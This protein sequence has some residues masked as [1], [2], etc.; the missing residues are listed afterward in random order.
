[1][2]ASFCKS[3]HASTNNV[4]PDRTLCYTILLPGRKPGFRVAFQP[5]SSRESFKIGLQAGRKPAGGPISKLSRKESAEFQPG[6]PISGPEALLRN[7]GQCIVLKSK[8]GLQKFLG[9]S[10][11]HDCTTRSRTHRR[12]DAQTWFSA[13]RLR[14]GSAMTYLFHMACST[15]GLRRIA[16][17]SLLNLGM[18]YNSQ[19]S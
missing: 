5:D 8:R 4:V 18:V 12:I 13:R 15:R 10:A 1:M 17:A 3:P 6:S 19:Y 11:Y 16:N 9:R 14:K 7:K 2:P